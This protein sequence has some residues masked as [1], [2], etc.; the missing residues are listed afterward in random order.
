MSR[1]DVRTPDLNSKGRQVVPRGE[2][3]NVI[4]LRGVIFV[5]SRDSR[6]R[7]RDF[8]LSASHWGVNKNTVLLEKIN[9]IS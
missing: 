4:G 3:R 2:S 6:E 5:V 9:D 8:D 7:I 1:T